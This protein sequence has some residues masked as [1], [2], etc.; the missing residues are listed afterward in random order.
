MGELAGI[1]SAPDGIFKMTICRRTRE[2]ITAGRDGTVEAW[3]LAARTSPRRFSTM[4][5]RMS[6]I[7]YLFP[8]RIGW[9]SPMAMQSR[10]GMPSR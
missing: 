3:S 5:R 2:L 10:F 6:K 7:S 1:G 9:R 4:G 8:A